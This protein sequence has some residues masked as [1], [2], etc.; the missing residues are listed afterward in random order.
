MSLVVLTIIGT[1]FAIIDNKKYF[2]FAL[3]I[4]GFFIRTDI[5]LFQP[6]F[7]FSKH[8]FGPQTVM[9][10]AFDLP[11]ILLS[12]FLIMQIRRKP[13]QYKQLYK[14]DIA[15]ILFMIFCVF[16]FKNSIYPVLTF[17]GILV[18]LRMPIIYFCFSR[19]IENEQDIRFI[20]KIF[21]FCML[22]QSLI[23]IAQYFFES[24]GWL[25]V[26]AE[27][28]VQSYK[29]IMGDYTP[30]RAFGTFSWTTVFAQYL[31]MLVPL[32]LAF[33]VFTTHKK[34]QLVSGFVYFITIVALLLSFARAAWISISLVF[35]LMFL[36]S[37]CKLKT[38]NLFIKW[39]FCTIFII[40]ISL[41][42]INSNIILERIKGKDFGSSYNRVLMNKVAFNIIFHRPI[43]GI[44]LNN[45]TEIMDHYGIQRLIPGQTGGVHNAFL[46]VAAEIGTVGLFTL[47]YL[48][49]ITFK[50]LISCFNKEN[51]YI[52]IT[53]AGLIC[54]FL[55]LFIHSNVE[56]GFHV[57]HQLNAML[58][59]FFGFA[60]ALKII[61][62]NSQ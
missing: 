53:S 28:K 36:L 49:I 27:S 3:L 4:I 20:I 44:G 37:L 6:F 45:Y 14:S 7:L 38:R 52:W 51:D 43:F 50:R 13:Y 59:S 31:A 1:L 61:S 48:W 33:F 58:W 60:G 57:H 10:Y 8:T 42:L 11:L 5:Y 40:V 2:L 25:N 47:L 18:M 12:L 32:S 30:N 46:Y 17:Y 16:S 29:M 62:R 21:M 9:I 55:A 19:G 24:L 35:I 54:S 56:P 34:Q 23:G 22:T 39:R 26:L 15:A 41:V